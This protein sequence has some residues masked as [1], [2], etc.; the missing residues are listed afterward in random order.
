MTHQ[1]DTNTRTVTI[2]KEPTSAVIRTITKLAIVGKDYST[3]YLTGHSMIGDRQ[4]SHI[5]EETNRFE[6]HDKEN[7]IIA[8]VSKDCPYIINYLF[9]EE[10]V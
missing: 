7:R 2:T 9:V 5:V 4:V 6:I 3:Y 1:P 10:Q 8:T